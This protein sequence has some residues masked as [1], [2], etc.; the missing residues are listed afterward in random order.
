MFDNGIE[1]TENNNSLDGEETSIEG[2]EEFENL[3]GELYDDNLSIDSLNELE[4]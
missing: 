2:I 3:N 1:D 4:E